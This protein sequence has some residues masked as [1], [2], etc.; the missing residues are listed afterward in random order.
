[1]SNDKECPDCGEVHTDKKFDF[2]KPEDA[3]KFIRDFRMPN[4][5]R[6]TFV[7]L[8]N[9]TRV[10][11]YSATDQEAMQIATQIYAQVYQPGIKEGFYCEETPIH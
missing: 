3:R 2:N 5:A 9:G 10:D 11:V 1:M 8:A 6:L 4:G 7:D